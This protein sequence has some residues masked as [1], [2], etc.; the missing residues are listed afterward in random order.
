VKREFYA[1][2]QRISENFEEVKSAK[3]ASGRGEYGAT[4]IARPDNLAPNSR[5][6]H[7]ET[8]FIVCVSYCSVFEFYDVSVT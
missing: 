5:G 3:R 1:A 2:S 6:G 7:R 8:C 4:K